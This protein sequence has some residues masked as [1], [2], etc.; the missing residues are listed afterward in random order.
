MPHDVR[1]FATGLGIGYQHLPQ[2]IFSFVEVMI[3]SL[4]NDVSKVRDNQPPRKAVL[5]L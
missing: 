5:D 1:Q 4:A 3:R 2:Q